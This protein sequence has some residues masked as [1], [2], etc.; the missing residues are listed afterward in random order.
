MKA[1]LFLLLMTLA[2]PI[3]S[4]ANDY[5]ESLLGDLSNDRLNPTPLALSFGVVGPNGIAGNNVVSGRVGRVNGEIDRDYLH[6]MVPTGFVWSELRVGNQTQVGSSASFIGLAAGN[7]MSVDP[8]NAH[9]ASGLLGFKLYN[10]NDKGTDILDN[11]AISGAGAS[12]FST[13]LSAGSYTLW[14]QELAP[15]NFNYRFNLII[16]AVPEAETYAMLIFGLGIMTLFARRKK[17]SL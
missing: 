16:T 14:I 1:A 7:I 12:G 13:P 17:H 8:N 15:G 4:L 9:N 10:L 6:I 2:L 5:D 11:M 3:T